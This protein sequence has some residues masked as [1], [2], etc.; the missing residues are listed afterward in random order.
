[1]APKKKPKPKPA[2]S[3]VMPQTTLAPLSSRQ[4]RKK[5][6]SRVTAAVSITESLYLAS[7]KRAEQKSGNNWSGYVRGLIESDLRSA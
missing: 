5:I 3:T 6:H 4:R 7:L 2:R 1:M